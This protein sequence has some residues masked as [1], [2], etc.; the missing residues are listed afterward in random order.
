MNIKILGF[1]EIPPVKRIHSSPSFGIHKEDEV[2]E[3]LP[4]CGS[5]SMYFCPCCGNYTVDN[6]GECHSIECV[7]Y[8]QEFVENF[9]SEGSLTPI[10]IVSDI[11]G[12]TYDEIRSC[13]KI[14]II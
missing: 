5:S 12:L 11:T 1:I 13:S 3:C 10:D 14:I 6:V 4:P 7:H 8:E 2:E 9:S